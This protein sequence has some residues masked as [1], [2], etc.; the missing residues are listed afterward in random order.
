M[1]IG[2]LTCRLDD[3]GGAP[4]RLGDR[5]PEG[6]A[7]VRVRGLDA[8]A[9]ADTPGLGALLATVDVVVVQNVMN[10]LALRQA[11]ATGRA[12]VT[13]QDHRV[14]C[15][16]PGKT[17][18]DDTDCDQE[19]GSGVCDA[20]LP[21]AG[22]RARLIALTRARRDAIEGARLTV[23]SRY[24]AEALA[25]VGLPGAEV[26]PPWVS[27]GPVRA[28]PGDG[29]LLGG[30]LVAHKAPDLAHAAWRQSGVDAP[31]RVAG[32]GRL[33]EALEGADRL[34]WLEPAALTAALRASRALLFPTR[35]QEPFGILGLEALAQGVPVIAIDRGGVRDWS[36]AGVIRVRTQ[37]EMADAIRHLH[38]HPDEAQALGEAGRQAVAARF[39]K[40]EIAARWEGLLVDLARSR[41]GG[42]A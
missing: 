20:C 33:A 27:A 41:G 4:E 32:A 21:D 28:H 19:F 37:Q 1:R 10:P 42:A 14:F 13:V 23:L 3:R 31:L 9:H 11:T 22:Y 29:F 17:L 18:P 16:G 34:G 36:D 15:P 6:G 2:V 39:A 30:R 40:A 38:A 25:A 8:P 5:W 35:W 24:M 12:V 7:S 26:I